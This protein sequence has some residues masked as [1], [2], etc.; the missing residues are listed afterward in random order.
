MPLSTARDLGV[1]ITPKSEIVVREADG[2]P[3][4]IEG[5]T[6]LYVR[7][8]K[9]AHLRR[10]KFM[11]TSRSTYTLIYNS[12]Q[13]NLLLLDY[14]Y[15]SDLRQDNIISCEPKI[16]GSIWEVVGFTASENPVL[17]FDEYGYGTSGK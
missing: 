5:A 11:V 6:A 9:C 4:R 2:K 10:L 17:H 8:Q 15:I 7:E 3:L 12:D 13:K 1:Q 16:I 14:D